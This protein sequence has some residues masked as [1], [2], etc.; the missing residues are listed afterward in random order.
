[1]EDNF[2]VFI[3]YSWDNDEHKIWVRNLADKLINDGIEVL[4]DQYDLKIGKSIL[5]FAE[6]SI[7]NSDRVIVV[8]TPNYLSKATHKKGGVGYEYSIITQEIYNN[9]T[10]KL[11]FIPILIGGEAKKCIPLFMQQYIYI[12]FNDADKFD[13]N[14]E[15][16]IRDL[17]GEYEDVKPQKGKKPIFTTKNFTTIDN[18]ISDDLYS[19]I[20]ELSMLSNPKGD[21]P[22]EDRIKINLQIEKIGHEL[23]LHEILKLANSES[24]QN[25]VAAGICLKS[26]IKTSKID[27]GS[28]IQVQEFI[29]RELSNDSVY[30]RYK[31]VQVINESNILLDILINELK[32][33]QKVEKGPLTQKELQKAIKSYV[34]KGISNEV[35][36]KSNVQTLISEGKTELALEKLI[37]FFDNRND[38]IQKDFLLLS[39]T[40][41]DNS[42]N[43][44]LGLVEESQIQIT[45][46]RINFAILEIINK[47]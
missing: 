30:V 15:N 37:S 4:L 44:R 21:T 29:T 23:E 24:N 1:M 38:E 46:N 10:E 2:K 19:T 33:R 41:S 12:D 9:Q 8:F 31:I 6:L 42:R 11:R 45:K 26:K 39:S 27:Y 25:K 17:Y 13:K 32:I 22:K 14:Y 40:L 28:D 7:E 34:L 35:S 36:L 3:S 20:V 43:F 5:Q 18:V 47:V 16:L